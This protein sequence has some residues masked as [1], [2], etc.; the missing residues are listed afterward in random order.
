MAW[1]DNAPDGTKSVKD[2]E[3]IL[4]D[5]TT[6]TETNMNLDHFWNVGADKDG[7]HRVVQMPE[8]ETGGT[9]DDPTLDTGMDGAIYLRKKTNAESPDNE[10]VQ[11]FYQNLA[12]VNAVPKLPQYLQLLGI[13][14]C[15]LVTIGN[16]PG[17]TITEKYNHNMTSI[18]RSGVGVYDILF[19]QLPS[20]YYLPFVMALR[21]GVAGESAYASIS[22]TTKTDTGFTALVQRSEVTTTRTDPSEL[23]YFVFGG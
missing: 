4:Q 6:Y 19:P 22:A 7:H 11:T 5:N 2:N 15:G 10:D 13:R 20:Q 23:W 1:N 12:T 3:T 14:S 17:F 9:P 18:T 8:T 21:N 16:S